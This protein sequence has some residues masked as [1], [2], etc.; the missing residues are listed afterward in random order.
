MHRYWLTCS[1][2]LALV[3]AFSTA[4]KLD[5]DGCENE[6]SDMVHNALANVFEIGFGVE[7]SGGDVASC[8]F[9]Q[10]T[11]DSEQSMVLTYD[12]DSSRL[13]AFGTNDHD[14]RAP[15]AD[16]DALMLPEFQLEVTPP[17]SEEAVVVDGHVDVESTPPR[18]TM[19]AAVPE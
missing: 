15:G 3:L 5:N 19:S 12:L 18:A 9:Y 8:A 1:L 13:S 2:F 17:G 4:C 11:G 16:I 10:D 14:V 6:S 7:V